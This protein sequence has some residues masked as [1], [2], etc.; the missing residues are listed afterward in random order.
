MKRTLSPRFLDL[1]LI[2]VAL[3]VNPLVNFGQVCAAVDSKVGHICANSGY[4][5][6]PITQGTGT[7]GFC[8]TL[9]HGGCECKGVGSSYTLAVAT[10]TPGTLDQV[11]GPQCDQTG[12]LTATST[13]TITP[14]N[15]YTGT[16]SFTCAVS[17]DTGPLPSC[18][19]PP[20]V[21][22]TSGPVTSTLSVT[23]SPPP[24]SPVLT[25]PGTYTVMVT[26][27]DSAGL[28]PNNGARGSPVSVDG[29]CWSVAYSDGGGGIALLTLA[30]LLA[31]W[32]MA[33]LIQSK[34]ANL[35]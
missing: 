30:G 25:P 8:T 14:Y 15:G 10:L 27:V 17:G 19:A 29:L 2:F 20:P 26:A 35:Q 33:R 16:V 23:V 1:L 22:V 28:T 31:L 24:L 3:A 12:P 34:R 13:V 4:P 9:R 18:S 21:T 6:S 32:S 5:C 11:S 7:T